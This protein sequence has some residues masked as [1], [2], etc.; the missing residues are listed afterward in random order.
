MTTIYALLKFISICAVG[1]SAVV[2]ILAIAFIVAISRIGRR[3]N[4]GLKAAG[5]DPYERIMVMSQFCRD[6]C[7]LVN[8]WNRLGLRLDCEVVR[9]LGYKTSKAI[10]AHDAGDEDL[11]DELVDDLVEY[12]KESK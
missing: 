10:A 5:S 4:R 3:K 12:A 8:R 2:G 6:M 11:F 1:M 7:R 9:V